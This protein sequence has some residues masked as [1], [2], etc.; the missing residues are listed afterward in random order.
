MNHMYY[1]MAKDKGFSSEEVF[2][3]EG[4]YCKVKVWLPIIIVLHLSHSI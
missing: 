4:R 3:E 2:Q 1:Y